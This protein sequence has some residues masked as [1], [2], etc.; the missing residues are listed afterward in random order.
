MKCFCGWQS[1]YSQETCKASIQCNP[2]ESSTY[3]C[4]YKDE[5]YFYLGFDYWNDTMIEDF[6]TI[7][8]KG[9]KI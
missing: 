6:M 5:I 1:I 4:S 8:F 3:T 7:H 9:M 2:K